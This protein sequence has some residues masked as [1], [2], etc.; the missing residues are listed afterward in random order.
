MRTTI[1]SG[2]LNV[3]AIC[4]LAVIIASPAQA[5]PAPTI[6]DF[7][8]QS[9]QISPEAQQAVIALLAQTDPTAGDL[10]TQ[11]QPFAYPA[12]TLGCGLGDKGIT[13]TAAE[14]Q[15]GPSLLPSIPEGS[16]RFQAVP[17]A[18]DVPVTSGLRVAWL[19]S[20]TGAYGFDPLDD[21]VELIGTPTLSKTV[22]T[23]KGTVIA[24]LFGTVKYLASTC[25]ILP[26]V[27]SFDA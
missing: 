26:T 27:G 16:L 15:A 12:P 22:E 1:A 19:N 2:V 6:E 7:L 8:A 18:L 5:A 17:A 21:T 10:V 20:G 9:E 4:G 13:L 23:G 11:I 14:A 24:A 3:I 25:S